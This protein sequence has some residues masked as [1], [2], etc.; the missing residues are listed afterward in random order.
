MNDPVRVLVTGVAGGSIG[1]QVCRALR[2]GRRPYA[3]IAANT[4]LGPTA[5]VQAEERVV[6]PPASR[7]DYLDALLEAAVRLR[8]RFLVPGS[9]PELLRAVRGCEALTGAGIQPL[10]NRGEIVT[11]C[12]DKMATFERLATLGFRVPG[13]REV[14]VDGDPL[15]LGLR[16]PCIVKPVLGGGGSAATFLAQDE[17]ELRFF[18]GYLHRNGHR[19]LVQEYVGDAQGEYT[20]GVLHAPDGSHLGTAVIRRQILGGLSN[21]LRVP[22][23]TSRLDLGPVLA[24]SSGISQGEVVDVA[25]VRERAEAIAVALRSA[26][27]LNIQG[28]WDG[29]EFLPFEINPRFSG[30]APL[31]AL[32]GFNEPEALIDWHLGERLAAPVRPRPGQ[33][34]RGLA[35]FLV[36]DGGP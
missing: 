35:E 23:R 14:G 5:V 4:A 34:L 29:S 20:V 2:L 21:R 27:P 28:R 18:V 8:A 36:E 17:A 9:E 13:T 11:T 19:A 25:E 1:E 16:L 26:G 12:V 33:V 24:V 3:I 31:R 10:V 30:T 7:E 15:A 6:L 22:N 32:A